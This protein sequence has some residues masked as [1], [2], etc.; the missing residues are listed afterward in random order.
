MKPYSNTHINSNTF[1]REIKKDVSEDELV[2]HRDKNDRI[3]TLLEG[4][5]WYIQFDNFMPEKL[6]KNEEIYV[7]KNTFHRVIKGTTDLKIKIIEQ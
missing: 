3:I 7:P 1:I 4:E 6:N 2:W 5:N